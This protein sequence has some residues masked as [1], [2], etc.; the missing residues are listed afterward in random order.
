MISKESS[1]ELDSSG[2]EAN[3]LCLDQLV[4]LSEAALTF[5]GQRVC[6]QSLGTYAAQ[7]WRRGWVSFTAGR[8]PKTKPL[9]HFT[10]V[11]PPRLGYG[12]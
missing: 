9:D 6:K 2:M 4:R 10:G 7:A 3:D 1:K 12:C 11:R 8:T 5:N